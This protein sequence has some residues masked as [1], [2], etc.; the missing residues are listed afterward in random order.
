MSETDIEIFKADYDLICE[1]LP[2][3]CQ[4]NSFD[5]YK[6][7]RL[8]VRSRSFS[9]LVDGIDEAAMMPFADMVNHDFNNLASW[10]FEDNIRHGQIFCRRPITKGAPITITYGPKSNR[11]LLRTYGFAVQDNP[12]NTANLY[13]QLPDGEG[14]SGLLTRRVAKTGNPD[15]EFYRILHTVSLDTNDD[16]F[17][18]AIALCRIAVATPDQ[19]DQITDYAA[20]PISLKNEGDALRYMEYEIDAALYKIGETD[21]DTV[22]KSSTLS[23]NER[24][25]L[26]TKHGER[27]VLMKLSMVIE[28]LLPLVD[29]SIS[30]AEFTKRRYHSR[31]ANHIAYIRK[32]VELRRTH[33]E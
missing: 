18:A 6:W 13:I 30:M 1:S 19:L 5:D 20:S 28:S 25:V 26:I 32:I 12:F 31:Y 14:P 23:D 4:V 22:L 24:N 10:R 9:L 16:D 17:K 7:G 33:L 2:E 3:F 29:P 15:T 8:A 21:D 27:D 11:V